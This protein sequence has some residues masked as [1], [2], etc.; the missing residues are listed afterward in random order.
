MRRPTP[1]SLMRK[2]VVKKNINDFLWSCL[3]IASMELKVD[4]KFSTFEGPDLKS[5]ASE[6]IKLQ[7]GKGEPSEKVSDL[8]GWINE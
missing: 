3:E 6:I 2:A 5:I 4:G 1:A 7:K 8:D